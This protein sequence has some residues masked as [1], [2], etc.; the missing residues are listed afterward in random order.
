MPESVVCD[1]IGHEPEL[2]SRIDGRGKGSVV[3]PNDFVD[4]GSRDAIDQSRH[5]P[6][7]LGTLRPVARS[8]QL[9]WKDRVPPL[10]S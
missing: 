9:A 2:V 7:E 8:S 4:L 10:D 5:R 1:I 3:I 6:S